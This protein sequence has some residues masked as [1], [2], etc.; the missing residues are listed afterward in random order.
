M[1][2]RRVRFGEVR[3]VRGGLHGVVVEGEEADVGLRFDA[4]EA[5]LVNGDSVTFKLPAFTNTTEVSIHRD[6]PARR[7]LSDDTCALDGS[8]Y[9][10]QERIDTKARYVS[11]S[12]C[13]NHVLGEGTSVNKLPATYALPLY[14]RY[15]PNNPTDLSE[16][17]GAIG[18]LFNLS[19]IHI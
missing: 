18:T 19:L 11:T 5:P 15:D 6:D 14:P 2:R 12:H 10:Y 7:R 8:D 17:A 16:R 3:T 4:A 1:I 13:P 9:D